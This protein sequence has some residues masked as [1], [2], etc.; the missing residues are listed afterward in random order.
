MVTTTELGSFAKPRSERFDMDSVPTGREE[1]CA[2]IDSGKLS[3]N[4][5]GVLV[6]SRYPETAAYVDRMG[7]TARRN[8]QED[9]SAETEAAYLRTVGLI[10]AFNYVRGMEVIKTDGSIDREVAP[11][12]MLSPSAAIQVL[13]VARVTPKDSVLELCSGFGYLSLPLSV[14]KPAQLDC[15]DLRTPKLYQLDET[16]K[17][18]YQWI[19][20]DLP[21]ELQP[22]ITEPN[23]IQADC[24]KSARFGEDKRFHPPYNKVFMHPP[25]GRE[26]KRLTKDNELQAFTLWVSTLA[27]VHEWNSNQFST[28]SVVPSEWTDVLRVAVRHDLEFPEALR[29]LSHSLTFNPYYRNGRKDI[30]K[31]VGNESMD[32]WVGVLNLALNA[33]PPIDQHETQMFP[34]TIYET[35]K[36]KKQER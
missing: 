3:R 17:R 6:R 4:D 14:C 5:V 33:R 20:G 23:F 8:L 32:N 19:Y 21:K 30:P 7:R 34:M 12:M 11:R 1:I 2:L 29:Y 27:A 25:F 10:G 18:A 26:S 28:Y 15:V 36:F 22:P 16:Q 31:A 35:S 24:R 9:S 13:S